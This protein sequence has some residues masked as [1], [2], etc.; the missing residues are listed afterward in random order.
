MA[1]TTV[2]L[3]HLGVEQMEKL[4]HEKLEF[5]VNQALDKASLSK[6]CWAVGSISGTMTI[7]DEKSAEK[8]K[9]ISQ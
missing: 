7:A 5:E 4:M 2:F 6:L 9:W 1:D 3:T 8:L